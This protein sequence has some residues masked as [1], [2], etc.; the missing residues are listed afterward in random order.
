MSIGGGD[1]YDERGRMDGS[2]PSMGRG[3]STRHATRTRL[4]GEDGDVYGVGRRPPV[5]AGRSLI[6]VVGVI[7]LLI[8]AIAFANRGGGEGGDSPSDDAKGGG[9]QPTAP[10][11]EKPVDGADPATGIASGFPRTEQGA[12]SAAANYAV[13]L[14]GDG[15]FSEDERHSIV[16]AVS[17]P[18][19]LPK[20]QAGFDADYNEKLNAKI[21]LDE[22]GNAPDGSTFVNR[23][24]PAGST[25]TE[26]DGESATVAV[27]CTSL[28]GITGGDSTKPVT[29][30]WF[31]VTFEL[32]WTGDDWK[33]SES[34]QK[35]GPTPVGGDNPI[36]GAEE[37]GKA[38]EEYGGFTY[39]R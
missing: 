8:A 23:T 33:V 36:S 20:L 13:A 32:T 9:A 5:R 21:G 38:V 29:S 34:S 17:D 39:A 18:S 14:G 11:G 4:P 30:S 3:G 2:D 6:T 24:I 27:W 22:Q 37:I 1:E 31:T 19:A 15:M 25:V 28:F 26:Y 16:A 35:S 10:T 7:V 12:Q